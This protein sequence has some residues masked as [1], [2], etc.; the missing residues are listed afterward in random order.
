[1]IARCLYISAE[2][3]RGYVCDENIINCGGGWGGGGG[4]RV[5]VY[6]LNPHKNLTAIQTITI[7]VSF[8]GYTFAKKAGFGVITATN[9]SA[10]T[11]NI[12]VSNGVVIITLSN[13]K[14][15]T[16]AMVQKEAGVEGGAVKGGRWVVGRVCV[17]VGWWGVGVGVGG[18][19]KQTTIPG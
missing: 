4:A 17:C 8:N 5:H 15:E 1:M 12:H 13:G 2:G 9:T 11:L 16:A 18:T 7:T 14:T 19:R 10:A 3:G 6:L